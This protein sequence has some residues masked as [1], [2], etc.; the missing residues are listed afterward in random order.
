[1]GLPVNLTRTV[2]RQGLKLKKQSPHIFFGVGVAGVVTSTVLACRA[3][4]K[5]SETLD[6]IQEDLKSNEIKHAEM[7]PTLPDPEFQN[8]T[9]Y[10]K[11]R[12]TIYVKG[13]LQLTK[14]YAPAVVV[15]GLSIAA[16]TGSH[17]QLTR[18]NSA[19]MAAYTAVQQAYDNYRERVRTQLGDERELELY[20]GTSTEIV[21][22]DGKKQEVEV[23]DPNKRSPYAKFFDEY[24][25]NWEKDPELNRL[26]IQCQQNYANHLL[27][28]RGH[29]FLNEVYDMLGIERSKAGQV[30][31][32]II[33]PDGDNFVDFGIFE[34]YNREFVNGRE[35]S[36]ILDFNVDGVIYDKI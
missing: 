3:T 18:R 28:A 34:A 26:F 21:K 4:L 9:N 36:I 16:L 15:G 24:T 33:G 8:E 31:G 30:V 22:V 35:R 20:R 12:V 11:G 32:W 14:L 19:L 27:V 23:L 2:L 7:Q 10:Q 5:L 1:M 29:I 25:K 17:V 13:G 6:D